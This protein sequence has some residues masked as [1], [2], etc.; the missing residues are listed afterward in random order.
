MPLCIISP[1]SV[2]VKKEVFDNIGFFDE[3]MSVCEDY[4]MW[5]RITARYP[6]LFV[7]VPLIIKQGGHADQLSKSV[8]AMDRF[9]IKSIVKI[10]KS[11]ALTDA[12]KKAAIAELHNK[13]NIYMNGAKK[14]GKIEEMQGMVTFLQNLV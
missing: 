13:L 9:R 11:D 2:V 12:M 14:R 10:I 8:K 1:S 4:D 5:L 6:V 7:D 3:S